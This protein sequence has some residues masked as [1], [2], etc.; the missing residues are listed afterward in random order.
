MLTSKQQKELIKYWLTSS[1]EKHKT[2]VGLYTL[3]RYADCL[4]FGHLI[5]EKVL[6]ALVVQRTKEYAPYT[7]NLPQLMKL[8]QILLAEEDVKLLARVNQFNMQTRYP[9]EKLEF[10]KISTKSYTD[11]YYKPIILLYKRLCQQLKLKK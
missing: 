7:H 1:K 9:D 2:M 10:Y 6:K 5:L 4:F 11:Q 8:S 3:K